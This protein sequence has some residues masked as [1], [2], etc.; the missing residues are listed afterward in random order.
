VSHTNGAAREPA[1]WYCTR[2]AV[3]LGLCGAALGCARRR[4]DATA[5]TV[6]REFIERMQR[7]HGSP[8]DARAA[9]ELLSE[10]SKA[11]LVERARR[12]SAATGRKMEPEHMIVPSRFSLRFVPRTYTARVAGDRAV[13]EAVGADPELEHASIP[14]VREDGLWRIELELPMLPPIE[15]RP[16]A[17]L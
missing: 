15:R 14:C 9:Y 17:G 2:R 6:V 5:E 1:A 8:Q 4:P 13:V 12:A 16:D 3:I 7:V 11:N 10:A